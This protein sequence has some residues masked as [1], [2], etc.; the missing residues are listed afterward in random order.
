VSVRTS[1]R[2]LPAAILLW[3]ACA[4]DR[5]ARDEVPEPRR[6]AVSDLDL[7]PHVEFA[8]GLDAEGAVDW[9]N[10]RL[11]VRVVLPIER[12]SVDQAALAS[13]RARAERTAATLAAGVRVDS[14]DT[15]SSVIPDAG[16]LR[17]RTAGSVRP[18]GRR[19]LPT[20]E[21]EATYEIPLTGRGGLVEQLYG[22]ASRT[23]AAPS[24]APFATSLPEA[25]VDAEHM[26]QPGFLPAVMRAL[27]AATGGRWGLDWSL[28]SFKGL[29]A[30]AAGEADAPV[31]VV[32]ARGTGILPALFPAILDEGGEPV[33]SAASAGR[34]FAVRE[35][36]VQYVELEPGSDLA[37]L[38]R[39]PGLRRRVV[40]KAVA[41]EGPLRAN[42]VLDADEARRVRAEAGALAQARVAVL[43]GAGER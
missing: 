2:A 13:A 16:A 28:G 34:D 36:L 29:A 4:P 10:L 7:R 1:A 12:D 38:A 3:S 39:A 14:R 20:G 40:V 23:A 24:C 21:L 11:V 42:V 41:A 22:R 5:L 31:I 18:L 27:V 19:L 6:P 33:Y 9:G 43:M 37:S 17:R 25:R 15:L 32:D 8:S 26:S 35:G 30:P